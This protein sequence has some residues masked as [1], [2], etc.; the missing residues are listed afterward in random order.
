MAYYDAHMNAEQMPG[1]D[2]MDAE[3]TIYVRNLPIELN[4]DGIRDI[5]SQYGKIKEM[6]HPR[7]ATWTYVTYGTYRE[8]ELAMRE[9]H[10]KKPLCLKVALAKENSRREEHFEKMKV[11]DTADSPPPIHNDIKYQNVD[12][13]QPTHTFHK[14]VMPHITVP[15]SFPNYE[16]LS[17]CSQT[18][19]TYELEDPY[20]STNK[21]WTR[22]IITVTPDGKRHVSLGR[23]YTLYEY[24]EPHPKVEEYI[25]NIYEQR[26]NGLYEYS[27]DKFKNEVQNCSVCSTKTTKHC[28]KCR[29]YYCSKACQL[30]DWPQHQAECERH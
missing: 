1:V 14:H 3:Y 20:M 7:R 24:P 25:S 18:Y 2:R 28:E 16:S 12:H 23:G 10:E 9:L 15:C 26:K 27:K 13:G 29:T 21:L 17:S 8:A 22:G 4:E 19:G 11:I 6:F 5:F 30:E